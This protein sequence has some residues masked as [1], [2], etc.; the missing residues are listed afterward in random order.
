MAKKELAQKRVTQF[1]KYTALRNRIDEWLKAERLELVK[2][3]KAGAVCPARG[4]YLIV[5][6]AVQEW[7]NWKG[8]FCK[9]LR[10][11][12]KTDQEIT[13]LI[14]R[15]ESEPREKVPRLLCQRNHNYRRK[16]EIRL[17]R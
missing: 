12:G 11:D 2:E 17:P 8:A 16:F 3:M 13:A 9:H 5:L 6:H 4:P 14:V 7:L 10:A 1:A 15:I